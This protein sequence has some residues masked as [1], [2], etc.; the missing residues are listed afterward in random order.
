MER[1]SYKPLAQAA[2]SSAGCYVLDA[3]NPT[4]VR[5][6]SPAVEVMT[7]LSKIPVATVSLDDT[8][9]DANQSMLLRGVRLL[10]VVS[11]DDRVRGVITTADLLGEKP[12]QVAQHRGIKRNELRVADVMT[13]VESMEVLDL[14]DVLRA[15]VGHIVATL[16]AVSRVH[17]IVV[18][19]G[20]DHQ[21]LRGIFSASQ[22]ARQLGV[23]VVSHEAARTFAEIEA[24][25][26]GV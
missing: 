9:S 17:A 10:L 2:I 18:E 5:A 3:H 14:G 1:P 25:I 19:Q 12:V 23:H 4:P 21:M 26:S 16:K 6:D 11:H 7:D 15:E 22:I 8:L 24:A 13:P 20:Q